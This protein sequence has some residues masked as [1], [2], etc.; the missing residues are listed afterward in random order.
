M[1]KKDSSVAFGLAL[2]ALRL[3]A[4]LSQH[5]LALEAGMSRT[6]V[7]ELERGVKEPTLSTM[8]R[9]AEALGQTLVGISGQVE[10]VL[11]ASGSP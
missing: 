6:Y 10:R 3:E 8:L 7:S 1:I 4:G 5:G 9:L 11:G 2:K